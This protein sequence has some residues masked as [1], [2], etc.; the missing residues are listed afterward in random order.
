ML[1]KNRYFRG[2][3]NTEGTFH[4][5]SIPIIPPQ[6][7]FYFLKSV[8]NNIEPRIYRAKKTQYYDIAAEQDV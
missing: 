6:T 5:R 3:H 2:L 8:G 4:I 7:V 1:P